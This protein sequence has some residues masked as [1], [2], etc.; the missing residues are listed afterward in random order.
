MPDP[1][2]LKPVNFVFGPNGS[3]KSSIAREFEQNTNLMGTNLKLLLYNRDYKDRIVQES[4]SLKGLLTVGSE[5]VAA[6]SRL[7]EANEKLQKKEAARVRVSDHISNPGADKEGEKEKQ[8]R[9]EDAIRNLL[10]NRRSK[11]V[12]QAIRKGLYPGT[13]GSKDAFGESIIPA[14]TAMYGQGGPTDEAE[15][16][17]SVVERYSRLHSTKGV[18]VSEITPELTELSVEED[19][20]NGL[21]TQPILN[22]G[23]SEYARS[24]SLL[25]AGNWFNRGLALMA[26]SEPNCP[27]CQRELGDD[28]V[29]EI[30][31]AFSDEYTTRIQSIERQRELIVAD[32]Q[33]L[34]QVQDCLVPSE[35][36]DGT[37]LETAVLSLRDYLREVLEN[38]DRKK[39]SPA[40]VLDPMSITPLSNAV[41]TELTTLNTSIK[42]LNTDAANRKAIEEELVRSALPALLTEAWT[43]LEPHLEEHSNSVKAEEGLA[44]NLSELDTEIRELKTTIEDESKKVRDSKVHL[45]NI[46]SLVSY[47]VGDSFRLVETDEG[48]EPSN[49]RVVRNDGSPVGKYLSEGEE[50][51][52]AFLYFISEV[53]NVGEDGSDIPESR[54]VVVI[55]DPMSSLDSDLLFGVSSL[56]IDLINGAKV[57]RY[58]IEQLTCLSHNATFYNNVAFSFK[59]SN[60]RFQ[61]FLIRKKDF[62]F[63]EIDPVPQ[64][65]VT[66][67]YA[68]LWK[69]IKRAELAQ[70]ADNVALANTMRRILENYFSAG[71]SLSALRDLEYLERADQM[72]VN[73]LVS[74]ANAGSHNLMD[75]LE[76][77]LPDIGV[78]TYLRVFK[79]IFQASGQE[80][81]YDMMMTESAP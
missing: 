76:I 23:D 37:A 47:M 58:H 53:W 66:S 31:N 1:L 29:E 26:K 32:I 4:N 9:I 40:T 27:F 79:M 13:T 67:V 81:H 48:D 63:H 20:L 16:L 43:E 12:P 22:E 21:L 54:A 8:A 72:A 74:W 28:L 30:K 42:K 18:S 46:N 64:S 38:I 69:S 3:G 49:Y 34:G 77:G 52:L 24:I 15:P 50:Q 25:E 59:E 78:A 2:D 45:G 73:S 35:V 11:E 70:D 60:E 71:N 41:F 56:I 7:D 14:T 51:L 57:G 61:H 10:W 75:S 80:A 19:I 33:A 62:G 6:K 44:A 65:P 55:D 36:L 17:K 5:A 39:D 68:N